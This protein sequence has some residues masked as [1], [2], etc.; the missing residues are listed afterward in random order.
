MQFKIV[1]EEQ[2]RHSIY[3]MKRR[4]TL[5]MKLRKHKNAGRR[6]VLEDMKM[7]NEVL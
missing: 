5:K 2:Q 6:N 1:G 7:M 3:L 4:L